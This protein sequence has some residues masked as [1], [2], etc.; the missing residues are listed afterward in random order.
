MGLVF[1]R[2][3]CHIK[4]SGFFWSKLD[5]L[6]TYVPQRN[7]LTRGCAI[8]DIGI[9]VR[10]KMC[11]VKKS[12]RMLVTSVFLLLL[13]L[14]QGCSP[15]ENPEQLQIGDIAPDIAVKDMKGNVFVLSSFKGM[16][17][18]LRFFETNCMFCKADTPAFIEFYNK[19]PKGSM[20][21]LYIGSFYESAESLKQ[22]TDDL[23]LIFPVALDQ[24][25]RLA[26]LYDIRAYPQTL[27]IG[28]EGTIDA[29]LLGGVG[30]A[31]LMEIVGKYL[32]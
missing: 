31:E 6:E 9:G 16:P 14:L 22:F 28:P 15:A 27:F 23:Q 21:I 5:C 2:D 30:E 7:T 19:Y 20:E 3:S 12:E 8:T 10:E 29:A 18:V 17:V 4:G 11:I 25:G 24:G 32:E 1:Y 26:D 13:L